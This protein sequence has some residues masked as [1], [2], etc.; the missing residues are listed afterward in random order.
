[1]FNSFFYCV[2][3]QNVFSKYLH[4][5]SCAYTIIG[6]D[7]GKYLIMDYVSLHLRFVSIIYLIF[8][9]YKFI[10]YT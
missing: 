3:T 1:M 2:K 5:N 8:S 10:T 6:M 7:L 9:I 4:K